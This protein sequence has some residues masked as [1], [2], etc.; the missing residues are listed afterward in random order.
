MDYKVTFLPMNKSIALKPGATLLHAARRAG[1][2]IT[3]RCDGKA[4]CLMCKVNVDEE[5]RK[6]RVH[7][8]LEDGI[9]VVETSMPVLITALKELNKVRRASLPGMIRAA[10]YK[11]T[12]WTTAD[13]PDLDRAQIGLKGSPTI[14]AKT[15]V[16]EN[17][18]VKTQMIKWDTPEAAA[19][20]LADQLL[21]K[22][23]QT[24]LD[25]L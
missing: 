10:R 8:L 7:R 25:W 14:V 4:A 21:T 18:A 19:A 12:V 3:T 2:K 23:M 9:E 22:D 17:K 15:W 6:V 11:P 20:Q 24:L 13:F 1:V 16:P 5:H